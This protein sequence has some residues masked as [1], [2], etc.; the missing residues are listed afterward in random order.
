MFACKLKSTGR[1][2]ECGG[3]RTTT[4]FQNAINAGY[5]K[6]DLAIVEMDFAV[7]VAAEKIRATERP[8]TYEQLIVDEQTKILRTQAI[9]NLIAGGKLPM[10]Y[11]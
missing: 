9:S 4:M 3:S 6:Q 2:L 10:D 1:V 7:F 11:K 8:K 5:D